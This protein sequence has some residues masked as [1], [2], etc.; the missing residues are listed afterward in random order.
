MHRL[1]DTS[2]S[3]Y[4]TG[5]PP[6][7]KLFKIGYGTYNNR[8]IAL[9]SKSENE[10]AYS[11]SDP[12]Y[13]SWSDG[14]IITSNSANQPFTALMDGDGNIY[15]AYTNSS[16]ADLEV[17]K[18]TFIAGAWDIG[19]ANTICSVG[20]N[21]NPS[22]EQEDNG[23]LWVSWCYYDTNSLEYTIRVKKST[24]GGNSW[25]LGPTDTGTAL[26][27]ASSYL[28]YTALKI[29]GNKLYAVYCPNRNTLYQR[30]YNLSD[31]SV[32]VGSPAPDF[33]YQ[34]SYNLSD[35]SWS[36]EE[37]VYNSVQIDY[38]FA[39]D[40]SPDS[41][42]GIAFIAHTVPGL[43]F[44]EYDSMGIGGTYMIEGQDD[45][46]PAV[47]YLGNIPYIFFARNIG[48]NQNVL[49]YTFLSEGSF[50]PSQYLNT[51]IKTFDIFLLYDASAQNKY[52]DCTSEAASV[53]SADV[54]HPE[55][56][57]L[58]KNQ[59]DAIYLGMNNRFNYFYSSLST[60]GIDGSVN[61]SYWNGDEW[62]TFTPYSG[63]YNFDSSPFKVYLWEDIYAT[64]ADWQKRE[65]NG[66]NAFWVKIE[67][68]TSYS[69]P[70]IGTQITAAPQC[71]YLNL[72]YN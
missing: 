14:T 33:L 56:S 41:K 67:V 43:C 16:A 35:Q 31:Q 36:S 21:Y 64:P 10:I 38:R 23:D 40:S 4:G 70:P 8:I 34:R 32:Q 54:F 19:T 62:E 1:I 29:S 22:L 17:I 27:T 49:K 53:D 68:G 26:S 69:T 60:I 13:S 66:T 3:F 7:E 6:G 46:S 25:G 47:R 15:I 12:P 44:K 57:A 58:I 50:T 20:N 52:Q 37:M 39:I 30:S 24:D 61:Y 9:F 48:E 11:W 28:G 65:V 72:I 45:S 5:I 18:L 42:L 71:E 63:A 59:G 2:T 55:S 51:G